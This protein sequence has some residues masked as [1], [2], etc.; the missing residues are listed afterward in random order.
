MPTN[1]E[2]EGAVPPPPT[3]CGLRAAMAPATA[4]DGAEAR[5]RGGSTRVSSR[6][7]LRERLGEGGGMELQPP[8]IHWSERAR[9]QLT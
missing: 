3:P 2:R 4:R 5:G 6:G 9:G 1:C 8:D 7:R